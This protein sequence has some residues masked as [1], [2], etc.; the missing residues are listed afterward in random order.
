MN[1]SARRHAERRKAV[2]AAG[3]IADHPHHASARAG[4]QRRQRME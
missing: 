2:G 3:E 1:R 4:R